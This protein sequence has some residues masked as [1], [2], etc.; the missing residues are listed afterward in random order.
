LFKLLP[1]ESL[2]H[3]GF[4]ELLVDII[5]SIR[6]LTADL[7]ELLTDAVASVCKMVAELLELLS[8]VVVSIRELVGPSL[9]CSRLGHQVHG[10]LDSWNSL[11]VALHELEW[12]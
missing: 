4:L 3:G 8:D 11:V 12:S 9:G 10:S 5:A 7:L 2:P 1:D 6:E